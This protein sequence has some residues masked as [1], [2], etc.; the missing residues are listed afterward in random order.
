MIKQTYSARK[1]P[2]TPRGNHEM[3]PSAAAARCLQRAHTI[4]THPGLSA[5][6]SALLSLVTLTFVVDLDIRT[7]ARFLGDGLYNGSP[8]AIGPL[9]CLSVL[10]VTLVYCGQT[11]GWI[12][13]KLGMQVGLGSGHIVLDGDPAPPFPKGHTPNVRPISVVAKWLNGLRCH[14]V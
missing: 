6:L 3:G 10:S 14:L 2:K 11:V 12:N 1:P 9:S 7:R 8:Y 5:A 4:R 13:K